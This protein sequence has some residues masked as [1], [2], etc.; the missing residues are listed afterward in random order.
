MSIESISSVEALQEVIDKGADE[1]KVV[2][3]YFTGK[4]CGP[5]KLVSPVVHELSEDY[6]A[7]AIFAKVDVEESPET[8][9]KYHVQHLP[10]ILAFENGEQV[11]Q[12]ATA[13]QR[14]IREF[15]ADNMG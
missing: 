11:G 2:I 6:C 4:F 9:A 5:C 12:I 13:D 7:A 15:V 14:K 3:V 1:E 10:T 8:A